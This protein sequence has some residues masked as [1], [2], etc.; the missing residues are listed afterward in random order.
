M[1]ISNGYATLAQLKERL[2]LGHTYTAG[3]ISFASATKTISDSVRGLKRFQTG[4]FVQVSGSASNDG[5]YTIGTGDVAAEIVTSEAL[6]DEAAGAS[7]TI[8][9]VDD[10]TD[11]AILESII[12]AVSRMIDRHCQRR[13]YTTDEDETRYYTAQDYQE[14]WLDDDLLSVTTLATD[15]N[16]DRSYGDTWTDSDY[17]LY[18]Y[19]AALDNKP[20]RAIWVND[21]GD[22]TFPTLAR[23]VAVT[24]KFGYCLTGYQPAEV[25]EACLLQCERL[26]K[27]KDAPFGVLGAAGMGQAT[28]IP[29]LD[30]DVQMLL[31][32]YVRMATS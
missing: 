6:T 4:D 14:A 1:T 21:N 8:T 28:V 7:V 29:Q 25:T 30:P 10:Q 17:D 16:G 27:R 23:A 22:Y 2:N 12:N 13:F 24:G 3:T 20:Y 19:N 5:Y 26:Y 15:P 18:P 9:V 11:D 31:S 32:A